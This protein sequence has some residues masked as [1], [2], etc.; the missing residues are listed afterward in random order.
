[1]RELYI[2]EQSDFCCISTTSLVISRW[3]ISNCLLFS[4][5]GELQLSHKL[6]LVFL[7]TLVFVLDLLD[8]TKAYLGELEGSL[9][10][11][12]TMSSI[13]SIGPILNVAPEVGGFASEALP[14]VVAAMAVRA[15]V[16]GPD[17][18]IEEDGFYVGSRH[19]QGKDVLNILGAGSS[20]VDPAL[21]NNAFE[22]HAVGRTDARKPLL[23]GVSVAEV[24]GLS[25]QM[26]DGLISDSLVEAENDGLKNGAVTVGRAFT[27]G[28]VVVSTPAGGGSLQGAAEDVT[29]GRLAGKAE[30]SGRLDEACLVD[31]EANLEWKLHKGEGNV[32]DLLGLLLALLDGLL[33]LLCLEL[34]LDRVS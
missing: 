33:L 18:A 20:V 10:S 24:E 6:L 8:R 27:L 25:V 34:S 17:M 13:H 21:D 9:G 4:L 28:L 12:L 22:E 29:A 14:V 31:H 19:E 7:D 26:I 1:L 32:L 5:L 16:V 15:A 30:I 23:E 2:D 11:T 3:L